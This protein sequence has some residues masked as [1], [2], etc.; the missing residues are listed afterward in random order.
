MPLTLSLPSAFVMRSA[1]PALG[2]GIGSLPIMETTCEGEA[3]SEPIEAAL[4]PI[5][6]NADDED[7][8]DKEGPR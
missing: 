7:D 5:E 6:V 1:M 3:D 4:L 8:V 2:A